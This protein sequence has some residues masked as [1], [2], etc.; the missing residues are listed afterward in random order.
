VVED[1]KSAKI[2]ETAGLRPN[3]Q[4]AAL[5]GI[6]DDTTVYEIP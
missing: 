2:L 1:P 3:M 6:A 4:V 5:R